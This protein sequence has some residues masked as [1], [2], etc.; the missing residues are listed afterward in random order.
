MPDGE[1]HCFDGD[2]DSAV[3]DYQRSAGGPS[4]DVAQEKI[5]GPAAGQAAANGLLSIGCA[6]PSGSGAADDYGSTGCGALAAQV[7]APSWLVQ[8][9]ELALLGWSPLV[10]APP[11]IILDGTNTTVVDVQQEPMIVAAGPRAAAEW[12]D[13]GFAGVLPLILEEHAIP[14]EDVGPDAPKT[15][16]EAAANP[17]AFGPKGG[18]VLLDVARALLYEA[19]CVV[20]Y[21]EPRLCY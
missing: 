17:T 10:P 11:P 1:F 9:G 4:S 15:L 6:A 7:T 18:A 8:C 13:M 20:D 12:A 3:A 5:H 19:Q 21:A 2:R 16:L 14:M